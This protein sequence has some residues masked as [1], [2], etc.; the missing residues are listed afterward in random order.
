MGANVFTVFMFHKK[1]L[2]STGPE[3]RAS[4]MMGKLTANLVTIQ[5]H[6]IEYECIPGADPRDPVMVFLH[7]GLGSVAMW[8]DFPSQCAREAGCAALVYSRY[9]YG[10]S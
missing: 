3:T 5:G 2:C 6:S 9:G 7:E 10:Q 8:K 4:A 1:L